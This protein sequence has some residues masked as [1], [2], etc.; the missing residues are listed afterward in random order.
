MFEAGAVDK[1]YEFS[2][3]VPRVINTICDLCLVYGF[4]AEATSI[5]ENLV[6]KVLADKEQHNSLGKRDP[7]VFTEVEEHEWELFEDSS[8]VQRLDWKR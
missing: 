6:D 5:S 4:A 2:E 7:A 1:I 8:N 3:G